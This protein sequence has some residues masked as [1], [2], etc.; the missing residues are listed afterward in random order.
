MV[1]GCHHCPQDAKDIYRN[2][3]IT[4]IVVKYGLLT[5]IEYFN[6][7]CNHNSTIGEN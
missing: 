1:V 4:V 6:I 2:I 3:L 5:E 7:A